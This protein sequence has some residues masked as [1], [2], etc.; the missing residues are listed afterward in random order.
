VEFD[1]IER[2]VHTTSTID[3]T[4]GKGG[5]VVFGDWSQPHCPAV[6]LTL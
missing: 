2:T 1:V 3:A 4:L 5:V 6:A